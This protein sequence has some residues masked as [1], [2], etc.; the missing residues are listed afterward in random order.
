MKRILIAFILFVCHLT[1]SMAQTNLWVTGSAVPNGT[2]LLVRQPD[3]KFRFTGAL[4]VGELKIMDTPDYQEG[5]TQFLAPV[6]VDSYLINYGLGYSSTTD[7]N[8]AGWVVSFQEDTYRFIVDTSKRTVTGELF[9]PWNELLIA[10]SA[11]PGGS[12]TQ[13]WKRDNMLPFTRDHDNP[14]VF[15]WEGE[16]GIYNNVIEPG[17]FK[18]EGQMTW[19][20][21]ELHP[22]EH[23]EDILD[24]KEVRIGGDDTKWRVVTPGT[25]RIRVNLF[26]QTIESELLTRSQADGQGIDDLQI[27]DSR[28]DSSEQSAN[29][30]Y[31]LQGRQVENRKS[32]NGQLII[33]RQKDGR[34]RKIFAK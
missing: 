32:A 22:Y 13:E 26:E 21:K 1:F 5:T 17:F 16:L 7:I 8:K 33:V 25:Y 24:A 29:K 3:G 20:P 10:G 31:D 11:F 30:C 28:F 15:V 19:G 14:Y 23:G 27:F 12:D 34:F 2:Q 9:L 6:L 18:L 4:N